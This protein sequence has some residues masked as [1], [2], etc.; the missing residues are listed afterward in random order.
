[1]SATG[2]SEAAGTGHVRDRDDWYR[3]P[4]WCTHAILPHLPLEGRTV[5]DPCA[6]DGA[7]LNAA[8]SWTRN[9]RVNVGLLGFEMSVLR[10]KSAQDLRLHVSL[11]DALDG[12]AWAV[13]DPI[14]VM[15]PPYR[16]A[17]AFV[18]RALEEAPIVAALLRLNWLAGQARAQFH[19]Q[20]PCNVYVLPKR[21]SFTS[22]GTDSC[23]Y[24]WMIWRAQSAGRW[25][26]L[27]VEP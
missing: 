23:D 4:D 1:M 13:A 19:R 15:N 8:R 3:T 14:V 2:R 27:E 9:R 6:G 11:R 22:G 17:M 21:P 25:S 12:A 24:A 16:Q 18:L 10:A 20:R 5:L 26:I 7:I